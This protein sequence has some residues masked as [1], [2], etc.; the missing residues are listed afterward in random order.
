MPC[1]RASIVSLEDGSKVSVADVIARIP[2]ESRRLATSPA[3]CRV[4]PI[5]SKREARRI[6]RFWLDAAHPVS[7]GKETKGKRRLIITTRVRQVRRVDPQVAH[8]DVFE[9][10]AGGEG[11]VI[12]D[13]EPNPHDILRL[14]GVRGLGRLP[15]P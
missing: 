4:W 10:R 1:L 14:Q 2:Q 6:P 5:C 11:R 12:A 8:F 9:G 15:G 3:V 13:G 7:F